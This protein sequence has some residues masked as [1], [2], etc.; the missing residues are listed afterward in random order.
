MFVERYLHTLL[1]TLFPNRF[2]NIQELYDALVPNDGLI[3][4]H[5]EGWISILTLMGAIPDK[6]THIGDSLH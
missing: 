4:E 3:E 6:F 1:S 2:E 5:T